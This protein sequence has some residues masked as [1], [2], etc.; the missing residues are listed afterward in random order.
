MIV[1]GYRDF[2][3]MI[4]KNSRLYIIN[5]ENK[6]CNEKIG[7]EM[8]SL[9]DLE[10]RL[11]VIM[12][13]EKLVFNMGDVLRVTHLKPSQIHYWESRGFIRP[14]RHSKNKNHVYSYTTLI[15]IKMIQSYL[16]SG[17]TLKVANQK[18]TH[19]YKIG[20]LIRQIF[21]KRFKGLAKI[22]D[23]LALDLGSVT[24]EPQKELFLVKG[25]NEQV[26]VKMMKRK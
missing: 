3:N 4:D 5:N 16:K 24:E 19:G 20:N 11:S 22:N 9:K 21:M 6:Y 13:N 8:N 25:K 14:V 7:D 26:K 1:Y 23:H 10:R 17:F 15:K 2:V 18:A 12:K